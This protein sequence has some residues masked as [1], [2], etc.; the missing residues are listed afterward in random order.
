MVAVNIPKYRPEKPQI[1]RVLSINESDM[2]VLWLLGTWTGAWKVFKKRQNREMVEVK[3]V[4]PT[5]SVLLAGFN[6]TQT[7]K[8]KQAT[9]DKLKPMYDESSDDE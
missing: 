4:I 1:G 5:A 7:G 6:L 8:L 3:E 2:E 9:K